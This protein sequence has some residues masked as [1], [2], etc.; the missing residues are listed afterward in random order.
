[1][2]EAIVY[3]IGWSVLIIIG[4]VVILAIVILIWDA[5]GWLLLDFPHL[6]IQ[7][8]KGWRK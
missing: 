4:G 7:K 2:I 3:T 6:I 5:I 8:Y 1:M